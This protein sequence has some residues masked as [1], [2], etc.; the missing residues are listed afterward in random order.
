M[1]QDSLLVEVDW[2]SFLFQPVISK[3]EYSSEMAVRTETG[4]MVIGIQTAILG[5]TYLPFY[6]GLQQ[7]EW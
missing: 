5:P 7:K 6:F 1:Q 2:Y 4:L 3:F